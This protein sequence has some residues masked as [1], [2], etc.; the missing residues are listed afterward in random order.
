MIAGDKALDTA[1][2]RA[3]GR[4]PSAVTTRAR[5]EVAEFLGTAVMPST[6][7]T[8]NAHFK[9]WSTFLKDEID[10]DDPFM[11]N[12]PEEEKVFLVSL[13]M[14][15]RH[16][17]GHK[18]KAA[19]SFTAA[20]KREFVIALLDTAFL[21]SSVI[22]TARMSCQI[23]PHELRAKNN[24]GAASTVKL[25]VCESI[26][27]S[28]RQ[29]L[30]TH[31]G[32]AGLDMQAR[33]RYLGCMWGFEMGARVSEYTKPEPGGTDHCVRTD[34]LT[35]TIESEGQ[36]VNVAGSGL[37]DLG[38]HLSA[39]GLSQIT[40]C[41]VRTVSSKGKLTVK[42]KLIGRRSPEETAFLDDILMFV[43][44]SGARGHEELLSCV[45]PDGSRLVLSSRAVRDELKSTVKDEGLP[46][47]YF[48]SHS[49]RKGAITHM[50]AL[51]ASED[52]RR[53]RGNFA[54]GSTVMNSTYDYAVT[55]LGPSA[56]NSLEGG[57]KPTIND[58]RR[59]V[60]AV[61]KSRETPNGRR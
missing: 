47:L 43:A 23:K 40:E 53:E 33:M 19:T 12:Q 45:R 36:V 49:L 4:E 11:K 13:M 37:A 54:Q 24:S 8:Y 58:L 39:D 2:K 46:E 7:R 30:W 57:C 31:R 22:H 25:P 18:G 28:L 10:S 27:T 32:W 50:R 51:G 61:R 17:A 20:L 3:R 29:R 44:H 55:G 59:L 34:D 15:R 16:Q 5:K 9:A 60:P 1:A 6:V 38:L 14:L 56:S 21:E 41:R 26:L 42:D 35:F 52:D 48:S